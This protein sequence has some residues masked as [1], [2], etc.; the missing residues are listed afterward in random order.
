MLIHIAEALAA[1]KNGNNDSY[2]EHGHE[3]AGR[4]DALMQR[5]VLAPVCHSELIDITYQTRHLHIYA[6]M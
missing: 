1:T 5:Y 3:V 4:T 6:E 2:H